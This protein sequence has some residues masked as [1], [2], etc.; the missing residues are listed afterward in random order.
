MRP[1]ITTR[2]TV[3]VALLDAGDRL[4]MLR[5]HHPASARRMKLAAADFWFLPGGGVRPGETYR[6]AAVREVFQETGIAEVVPGR[7]VWTAEYT[8]EGTDGVPMC[9][10]QRYYV[11]RVPAGLPVSFARH[12]PLEAASIVG[13]RWFVLSQ[14]I[15]REAEEAFRPPGLG[16]L[17]G[18][19]LHAPAAGQV[20]PVLLSLD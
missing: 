6:Q 3:R 13:Y 16:N 2:P 15:E 14:I 10:I 8:A 5:I 12:E 1:Q 20:E 7:C 18:D 4:F 19:L 11:A 17:F 9:V